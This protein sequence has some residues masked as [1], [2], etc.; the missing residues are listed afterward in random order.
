MI[1]Q[2]SRRGFI[3]GLGLL[4]ATPAIVK[5]SNLMSIRGKS[6]FNADEVV[7]QGWLPREC[8]G[9][10]R[11]WLPGDTATYYYKWLVDGVVVDRRPITLDI[12][13]KV[14]AHG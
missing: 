3:T 2:P 12:N 5:A 1:E 8:G 10:P 6:L 7:I 14:L 11:E 13:W 4:I 9:L